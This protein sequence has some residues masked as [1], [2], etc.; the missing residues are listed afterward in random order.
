[1]KVWLL[2]QEQHRAMMKEEM[3][4]VPVRSEQEGEMGKMEA[5]DLN[6]ASMP[7]VKEMKRLH[8]D[9][10]GTRATNTSTDKDT[11]DAIQG[12]RTMNTVTMTSG[13]H[14]IVL[15]ATEIASGKEIAGASAKVL[16]EYPSKKSST[17]ELKRIMKH[18][19]SALTLEEKGEYRFTVNYS[20][21]GGART[22]QFQYV[23]K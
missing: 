16:I 13:T 4:Q 12:S 23:V 10:P 19:G 9:S 2:T 8:Q 15:D 21:G 1:M 3:G 18:F 11:V 17:V 7:T 14:D 20:F 6:S 22:T 5:R